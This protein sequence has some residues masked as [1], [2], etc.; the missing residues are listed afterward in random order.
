M[1]EKVEDEKDDGM[2]GR[3]EETNGA[4]KADGGRQPER[5]VLVGAYSC[6]I[7]ILADAGIFNGL[8]GF[9][10]FVSVGMAPRL[11]TTCF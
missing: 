2:A 3:H 9:L 1:A 5:T 6:T 4:S 11:P 7:N 10:R 8:T